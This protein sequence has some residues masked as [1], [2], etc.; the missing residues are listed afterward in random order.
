MNFYILILKTKKSYQTFFKEL[1]EQHKNVKI[2]LDKSKNMVES[3]QEQLNKVKH[4]KEIQTCGVSIDQLENNLEHL[5][6]NLK[7]QEN[8]LKQQDISLKNMNEEKRLLN[9]E[10]GS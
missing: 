6:I 7:Q 3:L 4:D 5:K 1:E 10:L 9:L 2:E 8:K